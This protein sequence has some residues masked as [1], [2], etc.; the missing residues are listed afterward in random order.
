MQTATDQ[1]D[2]IG[3]LPRELLGRDSGGGPGAQGRDRARVE[4][5]QRLA[6]VG[7]RHGDQPG[8]RR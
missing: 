5:G 1:A 8:D 7:V 3:I 2:R 6:G 4:E